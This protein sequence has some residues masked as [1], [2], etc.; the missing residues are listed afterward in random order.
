[1]IDEKKLIEA[2]VNTPSECLDSYSVSSVQQGIQYGCA[3]RQNEI[4]DIINKQPKTDWIPCEERLPECEWGCETKA[5]MY[6]LKGTNTIQ[7]CY[8][9]EGGKYRDRYFRTYTDV[10]EGFDAKDVIAWQPLPQP[11]KKEGG[12]IE[13]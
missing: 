9:G 7:V 13:M 12:N 1:M 6:Q 10:F 2:I 5:L 4:I 8:Y 11:Y 3:T